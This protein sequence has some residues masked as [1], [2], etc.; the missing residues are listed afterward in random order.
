MTTQRKKAGVYESAGPRGMVRLIGYASDG[1]FERLPGNTK[2]PLRVW[3]DVMAEWNAA[4]PP[5][6]KVLELVVAEQAQ[7]HA[8]GVRTHASV[9]V[10]V[11]RQPAPVV[12]RHCGLVLCRCA[13]RTPR[14]MEAIIARQ[15][16]LGLRL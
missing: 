3:Q 9:S 6:P 13:V 7:R 14:T 4:P 12:C 15:R 5:P 8:G 16:E 1:R 2:G 10:P 11:P